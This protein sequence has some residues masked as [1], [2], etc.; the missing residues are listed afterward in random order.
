VHPQYGVMSRR[1]SATLNWRYACK[2]GN[3]YRLLTLP[4][5]E[6]ALDGYAVYHLYK[7]E[8]Q[9]VDLFAWDT[10]SAL[11]LVAGVAARRGRHNAGSV[12]LWLSVH[13]PLHQDLERA[14]FGLDAPVFYFS[15]RTGTGTPDEFYDAREWHLAMGDSD[16]F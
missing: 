9:I 14:G 4:D 15:G 1:D 10:D 6:A 7:G 16:V 13:D 8:L 5:G 12:A 2:P 3:Q 11:R